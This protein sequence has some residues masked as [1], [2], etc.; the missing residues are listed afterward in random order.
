MLGEANRSIR[1][2]LVPEP[3]AGKEVV[4]RRSR[5]PRSDDEDDE[6]REHVS[7]LE[8]AS[9]LG[10]SPGLPCRFRLSLHDPDHLRARGDTILK[11][12]PLLENFRRFAS[13]TLAPRGGRFRT[14][15]EK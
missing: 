8:R 14:P 7:C 15:E 9:A 11:Q 10:P 3:R 13:R 6:G 2:H 12:N 4:A 5:E 1:R